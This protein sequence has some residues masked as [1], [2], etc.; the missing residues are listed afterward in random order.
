MTNYFDDAKITFDTEIAALQ[1]VRETLD[2]NFDEVVEAILNTKGRSIFIAIGK[3]G[4]IAEKIAASLSSVGVPS[5]FID[6]GTAYH[7]DLGRVSADDLVIFISNSGETQEVVQTLFAL[8]NIHQN[9]LKTIALT[10][11]EDATLAKNTDIFLKVDVAEEADPTELAPT[12]STTAT[13]VMGD[14]LLIAVEKAK[15]FKRA[16]FA[17]YHPGG[18]I[19]KMLLRDVAHSMHTKIP[20]VQTTTPINDV[21][22]RISDF[23]VG[24]TLVKTPEE[25][26]IGI[27]TDGDIRK[28]F[29]YINQVKN[30]T[31]ADYMTEGFISINQN[32]RNS[33]AWKKMASNNIS[34][35]V[36]KDDDD[37][38]VGIITI[39]DVL[40]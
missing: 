22:Y 6:A 29:L 27:I 23:G 7:G 3:S 1:T 2:E 5:F 10:G 11:S 18:S 36:V 13:L 24:M 31:A 16:D 33:A 14:A 32:A 21:I 30:S 26:V 28:K 35:L 9:E 20:Y 17:L 39:H 40:E 38:V 34:N 8:K 25:K 4:I 37:S 15:A 19:G 12:S